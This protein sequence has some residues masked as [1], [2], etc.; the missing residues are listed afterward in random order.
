MTVSAGI[1][2]PRHCNYFCITVMSLID[3][4]LARGISA[5]ATKRKTIVRV[6][7]DDTGT[8]QDVVLKKS[9]G[10]T[11]KDARALKEVRAMR[12]PRGQIGSGTVRRWHELAYSIE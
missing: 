1:I 3:K 10:D 7:L 8:V 4:L 5:G 6:L 9:C 2:W 11:A 12:F